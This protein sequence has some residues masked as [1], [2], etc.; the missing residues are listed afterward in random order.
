MEKDYGGYAFPRQLPN[1]L[2]PP[3]QALRCIQDHSGMSLR[4]WFSGMALSS[5]MRE[6]RTK[7]WLPAVLATEAYA[8]ADAM[9]VER[10]SANKESEEQR[11]KG[12]QT[13][14]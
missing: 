4:D 6:P 9:L 14:C 12:A 5:V 11:S 2:M 1:G 8:V 3:D 7:Q 13:S 10:Q